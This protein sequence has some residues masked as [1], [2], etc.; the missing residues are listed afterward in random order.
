MEVES[1]IFGL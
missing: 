1:L